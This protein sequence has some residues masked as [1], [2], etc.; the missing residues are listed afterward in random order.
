VYLNEAGKAADAA[1][2]GAIEKLVK[3]GKTVFAV[4]V[5][6]TG[7]TKQ[8]KQRYGAPFFGTDGQDVYAAYVMGRSYV[9]MRAE[10]I[11]VAARYAISDA[12]PEAKTV[13]LVAIGNVGVPALHA[14]AVESD[15]FESVTLRGML[16]SWSNIIC[17]RRS[18]NQLVNAVHGALRVY[19]LDDLA[20]VIGDK[21]TIVQPLDALGTP[22]PN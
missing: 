5:R 11:L 4:E 20:G 1:L 19:D 17:S 15:L 18:D 6:G 2:D 13:D 9:A 7:E 22:L 16:I 8:T 12:K 21:I 3:E 14:A 10:D